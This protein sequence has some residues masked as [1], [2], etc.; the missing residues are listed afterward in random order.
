MARST[1]LVHKLVKEEELLTAKPVFYNLPTLPCQMYSFLH[2][3]VTSQC[4]ICWQWHT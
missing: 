1:S 2:L 4:S 3:Q